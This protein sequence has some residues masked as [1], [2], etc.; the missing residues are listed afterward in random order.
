[1]LAVENAEIGGTLIALSVPALKPLFQRWLS[2]VEVTFS[3]SRNTGASISLGSKPGFPSSHELKSPAHYER[4]ASDI[5]EN[6]FS[7]RDRDM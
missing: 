7:V 5:S 6:A 2:N 4:A 1:M 3:K